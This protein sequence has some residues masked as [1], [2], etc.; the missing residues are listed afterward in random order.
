M[1]GINRISLLLLA[2]CFLLGP[3]FR[4]YAQ[5][6]TLRVKEEPGIFNMKMQRRY[7]PSHQLF[8][9]PGQNVLL[10]IL[11][12]SSVSLSGSYHRWLDPDLS[13]GP[14]LTL[15]F[16]KW[17]TPTHGVRIEAGTGYFF[18]NERRSRVKML[19][20]VRISHL[21]N[22]SAYLNGYDSMI[23]GYLYTMAGAGYTWQFQGQ[24][25]RSWTAQLGLGYSV[26]IL[27]G[28]DL[29]VEPV[30][31]I[32]GN[33]FLHKK[34]GNW[35]GYFSGIRGNVGF[36]YRIDRWNSLL[37]PKT[38][39]RWFLMAT[40]GPAWL[41]YSPSSERKTG[42]QIS[43]GAGERLTRAASIRLS[44]SWTQAFLPADRQVQAYYG[45]LRL[46]GLL[47]LMALGRQEEL[48]WSLTVMA[49]PEV[50]YLDRTQAAQDIYG[51][52]GF[53]G[54]KFYYVGATA[55][56]QLNTRI[57]KRFHAF[58][59]PRAS[60]IPYT[61]YSAASTRRGENTLD[62]LVSANLG[63]QY[64]IPTVEDRKAAWERTN[65]WSRD[66]WDRTVE[67]DRR[68]WDDVNERWDRTREGLRRTGQRMNL[69]ASLEGSYFR[70]LGR[71][72]ANGPIASLSVGT[73]FHPLH[74]AMVN[75][76]LGYF[77]DLQYG[78]GYVKTM[79]FST[80]YLFNLTRFAKGADPD[81]QVNLSLLAGAGYMMPLQEKWS[82]SAVFRSGLDLRMHVL[83]RTDL[84]IRPE[85]D[86]LKAPSNLWSPAV[87]GTFGL[88]YSM[89]GAPVA[90]FSD[91][92]KE[93]YVTVGAGIQN[94]ILRLAGSKY[95][96]DPFSEYRINLGV[97][98]KYTARMDWRLSVSY[99]SEIHDRQ[100]STFAH[101][102]RFASINIDALYNLVGDEMV[103]RKWALSL[104][105]GPEIGLQHKGN[106][107]EHSKGSGLILK[108]NTVSA[109]LGV[110]AGV[111]MK[112]RFS[113]GLSVF[114]E[115]K[116]TLA[117]YVAITST[118]EENYY[119]HIYGT[120]FG[121]E[122]TFGRNR[123]W[124]PGVGEDEERA[125]KEKAIPYFFIQT[126]G[127]V[128][129]PFGAGYGQGPLVNIALGYWF[130]GASGVMLDYGLGY[131]RDN[132]FTIGANGREYHPQHMAT[133]SYR[134]SYLFSLSRLTSRN[135]VAGFPVDAALMGGVGYMLP[136][137]KLKDSGSFSAH[138][139]FDFRI[140]VFPGTDL[141]VE[142]QLELF[143]DPHAMVDGTR[144]GLAG[145]FRG[146]FG[147]SYNLSRQGII[148]ARDPGKD[149]F[150]NIS[151]GY[152]NES[153][154][155]AGQ[156][157]EEISHNEYR[158]YVGLGRRYSNAL[159]LRL[160]GSYS[161]IAPQ[162]ASFLHSL[163]YTSAN[164]DVIYDLLANEEGDNRVSLGLLGGPEF[165]F[166]NKSH[167]KAGLENPMTLP[168]TILGRRN[169]GVT[170]YV[171]LSA[172]V[173]LKV[174]L[175]GGL[176][177]YLEQRYSM[178]PYVS[179]YSSTDHRNITSHL[180]NASFGV[181]YSFGQKQ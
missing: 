94:E 76:G 131:F 179:L 62:I 52:I 4:T 47:D 26:H 74:G 161:K 56:I 30:L 63:L 90:N 136:E 114:V 120:N 111:Q 163:R 6:D 65:Q 147:A 84:V 152:Q 39:H 48:P 108:H 119:S 44:G 11:E 169:H 172:G 88:S 8:Y 10:R 21:F 99:L 89:G 143:K 78:N 151:A 15:S 40:G 75:T 100:K 105:G 126:T 165:G 83:P 2:A 177:L 73:W 36:S 128:I 168:L 116:Y 86:F 91:D 138:A 38:E 18:N 101:R 81:R 32:N 139:G 160:G 20:D 153:S 149:W 57:Y 142:P 66:T 104:V 176:F 148:P 180:W 170:A 85:M 1:K 80:A 109:Y 77:Q 171:G 50:G 175:T 70:P 72:F 106:E 92:G 112:Y 87:R 61:V 96:E 79:E 174:R 59:E 35:R 113:D 9:E 16:G 150:I 117:P 166:A 46:E 3:A 55:G 146:T 69:F 129:R 103:D 67:W 110:S 29:F 159:S 31:E 145:A 107:G 12:N 118:G 127:T 95:E 133:M 49:G 124:T 42:Y 45:A 155:L 23:P 125:R 141:V 164:L 7:T 98:R 5:E 58:L 135:S 123:Y 14:A 41:A 154:R 54:N 27:R 22:L 130:R 28:T 34:D 137:F 102:L 97:G 144:T 132:Q 158:I 162:E 13:S 53:M 93:W 68:T 51:Q 122:Y 25:T 43:L 156:K 17:I 140:H 178:V 134:A 181:Q 115:P 60:L 64:A 24:Q 19:P 167:G 157:A 173:Q 82:G 121:L 33:D 71:D 37:P